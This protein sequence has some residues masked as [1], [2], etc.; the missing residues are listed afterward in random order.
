MAGQNPEVDSNESV[1]FISQNQLEVKIVMTKKEF[2]EFKRAEDILC[3]KWKKQVSIKNTLVQL[4][5]HYLDREDPVVK[6]V[7]QNERKIKREFE[8]RRYLGRQN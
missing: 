8:K 4:A 2:E 5:R 6:A 3:Q 7:K 1:R